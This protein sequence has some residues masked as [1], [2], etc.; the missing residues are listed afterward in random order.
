[1]QFGVAE[2]LA[3]WGKYRPHSVAVRHNGVVTTYGKLNSLVNSVAYHIVQANIPKERVG[4]CTKSKLDFLV[5]LAGILRAGK[6]AVLLN[7]GLS[8]E[9]LK[10][11]IMDAEVTS[12]IRDD[13]YSERIKTITKNLRIDH[14]LN[15]ERIP[16]N[17]LP[18]KAA[19]FSSRNPE[20]EWGVLYSS[21]TTGIPKGIERDHN[22]MITELLGWCLE[23]GLNRETTFYIGRPIYYTGGLVLLLS[24]FITGGC[25]ILN[26]F[27]NDN[28]PNEIWADYQSVLSGLHV[29]WAFFVPEQIRVFTTIAEKM[30]TSPK[31][32][33]GILVMG[34][35]ISGQ[36][37]VKANRLLVCEIVESWG[38]SESL[39]T[40]TEPDDI[41]IRPD[42][43]GRPF[44]TDELYIVDDNCNQITQP[45]M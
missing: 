31:A 16:E 7:M 33:S 12:F 40:I 41:R 42:S 45:E 17:S 21:G 26:D 43:I 1:M 5:S 30:K 3:H 11:N 18:D 2:S 8:D 29:S 19:M 28:D 39:G 23:L 38:N 35:P 10:V 9:A 22:S 32:A 14:V 20:D 44:L 4:I 13:T 37:K 24:T 36:E 27:K 34:A 15:I 25:A 6:S